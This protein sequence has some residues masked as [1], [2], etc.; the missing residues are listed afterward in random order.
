ME[1]LNQPDGLA[2]EMLADAYELILSGWCQGTA[3]QDEFGRPVEPASAS[4]RR[5]SASG[6]LTRVWERSEERFGAALEAFYTA[7]LALTT[8]VRAVPQAWN[9]EKGR[10]QWQV[11]D[12]IALAAH[13]VSPGAALA[14]PA[15][16]G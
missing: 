13:E 15:Q 3:A 12:A 10:T 6:A 8:I 9:D 7:N 14:V 1:G 4:A 11:L 2:E 16:A 5:W